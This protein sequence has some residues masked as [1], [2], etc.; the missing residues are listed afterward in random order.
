MK[1]FL[2]LGTHQFEGL[3]EFTVKLG[4]D[5][6]FA[7]YCYE[8]NTTTFESSKTY[9]SNFENKFYSFSHNNL[10]VMDYTGTITFNSH[11]GAWKDANKTEY[12]SG[13]TCGS[14]SLD[15]NPSNDACNGVVFDIISETVNCID[16]NQIINN[17]L[18]NDV[19]AEIYIKCDIEGSEFKVL[20]KLL[21]SPYINCIKQI[22]VEWHER[23][24]EGNDDYDN[25]CNE[26]EHI[27]NQFKNLNIEY[28][29]HY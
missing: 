21:S 27:I 1:H 6:N 13:Y 22:Y 3:S 23:F 26:K 10:A 29:T 28:F 7:V 8:P 12:I 11:K 24:W 2:D 9:I 14:N 18:E 16:I 17:I 25:K 4:I 19:N 20:P 5:N 15:I